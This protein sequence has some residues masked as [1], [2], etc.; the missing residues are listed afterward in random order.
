MLA[1]LKRRFRH[2]G[3]RAIEPAVTSFLTGRELRPATAAA[4]MRKLSAHPGQYSALNI[5]YF[6]ACERQGGKLIERAYERTVQD[7]AAPKTA[8]SLLE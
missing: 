3:L 6:S 1:H 8:Q 2:P 4:L 7:W 5:C